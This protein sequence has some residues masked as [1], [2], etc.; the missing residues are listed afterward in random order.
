MAQATQLT[1]NPAEEVI[2]VGPLRVRFLVTGEHANG[3]LAVFELR[4]PSGEPIPAP[5]HSHDTYEETIYGLEG[6]LTWTVDG[7]PI[8]VGPGQALSI[9]RGAVQRFDN[10]GET[11]ATMLIVV[12]PAGIGPAY[13]REVGAVLA[14]AGDGPPDKARMMEIMRRH[15]L[16]PAPS[17][18]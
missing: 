8:A 12:S 11:D 10:L 18:T 6:V 3:S 17:G 2:P 4:V 9:P 16:S 1:V 5:A 15:G 7:Q 13:F 14:A